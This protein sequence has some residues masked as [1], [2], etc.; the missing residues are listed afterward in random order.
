MADGIR[1]SRFGLPLPVALLVAVPVQAQIVTDGPVAPKA[2]VRG[3]QIEISADLGTRRGD[4]LF[5]RF[6]AFSIAS[7]QTAAFTG[8]GTI[9]NVISR[10][11]GG[12]I[13]NIDGTFLDAAENERVS[14]D[15]NDT[16]I[17]IVASS[18]ILRGKSLF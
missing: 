14:E 12:E 9:R 15:R 11:T 18:R 17:E 10:V 3:G 5:H 8:S 2:S 4:N 6:G 7:G 13:S 16:D 1:S